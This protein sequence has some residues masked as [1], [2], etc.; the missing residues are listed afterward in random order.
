MIKKWSD[1]KD[2][3]YLIIIPSKGRAD[4]IQRVQEL[5][6]N[7]VLFVHESEAKEYEKTAVIPIITH[8]KTRGYG[9]VLNEIFKQCTENNIRYSAVFDDDKYYFSSLVGNRQRQLSTEQIEQS[10]INGCQVLEDLDSY[11]YLFSTASSIIKYSQAEPY[12]IGFSLPQGAVIH[13]NSKMM[14]YKI[15][16]HYHEDFDFCMDYIKKN[17]Y[18]IVEMRT[19]CISKGEL[20]VGGCNSFRNEASHKRAVEYIKK[21]WGKYVS[22]RRNTSGV[23]RPHANIKFRQK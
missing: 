5:F 21:K 8:K 6:P 1:Y 4:S 19:L 17:K 7:G 14:R 16:V 3:D 2:L 18:Y 23:E 11:M 9:D 12:K 15:G 22:F 13:R 20:N 10:I